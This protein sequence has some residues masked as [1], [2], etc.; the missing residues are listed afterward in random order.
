MRRFF[1]LTVILS[2]VIFPAFSQ[3]K[4]ATRY[5]AAKDVPLKASTGFFA[6]E[7][8]SLSLGDEVALIRESG[9]WA[10][11][12]KGNLKGWLPVTCL[13]VRRIVASGTTAQATEIALAGKGFSPDIEIEYRKNGLDYS[14]VDFMEKIDIPLA[15]LER[16]INEGRLAKGE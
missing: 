14:V 9:K 1:T 6:A 11:V 12:E 4:R 2:M 16:F 5:V 8:V 3:T 10:E 15:D 13:S 7:L